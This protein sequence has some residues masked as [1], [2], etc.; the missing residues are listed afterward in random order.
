MD[1]VLKVKFEVK[2]I[3]LIKDKLIHF[4]SISISSLSYIRLS[5]VTDAR[6]A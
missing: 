2:K 4:L 6:T 1:L 5:T 3:N